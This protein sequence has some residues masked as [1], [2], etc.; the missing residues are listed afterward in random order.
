MSHTCTYEDTG[1]TD[2][3]FCGNNKCPAIGYNG[4]NYNY[5]KIYKTCNGEI[6]VCVS[7]NT[8]FSKTCNNDYPIRL[9]F[10]K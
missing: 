10:T 3:I 7:C 9:I 2:I 6:K 5:A 8:S 4:M 1:K